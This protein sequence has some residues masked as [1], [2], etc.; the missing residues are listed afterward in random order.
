MRTRV[1]ICCMRSPEDIALAVRYGADALGFVGPMPSG[2]GTRTLSS[3]AEIVPHVPPA[4]ASVLLTS[5][6]TATEILAEARDVGCNTVQIVDHIDPAEY[7][8]L[9]RIRALRFLQV[10]HVEDIQSVRLAQ[11]YSR[12]ADG[13]LLDSG[14]PSLGI[15][16]LGGT[17]RVHDWALSADIVQTCAVPVF[18]AGGLDGSNVAEAISTVRP[19]GVDVCSKLRT[20]D[21]LDETKLAAFMQAVATA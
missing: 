12:F 20:D 11:E 6:L 3:I 17:G 8:G 7:A 16:E 18:L 1:K 2:A 19:Y 9:R 4:V 14:R 5:K 13:L 15:K 10:V 21:V